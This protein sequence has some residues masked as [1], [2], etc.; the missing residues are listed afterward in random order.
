MQ[1]QII[2][3]ENG[4]N[5]VINEI[6]EKILLSE[7]SIVLIDTK[8]EDIDKIDYLNNQA[9][10]TLKNG[11]KIIV[12]NFNVEESSLVFRN[13]QSELFIYDFN[14]VSYNPLSNIELLLND[15][16]N[17]LIDLWPWAAGA[18]AIGALAGAGGGSSGK[19]QTNIAHEEAKNVA[20]AESA[21]VDAIDTTE[22]AKTNP[23]EETIA[24]A[25]DAIN[26]AEEAIAKVT[27]ADK[28]AELVADLKDAQDNLAEAIEAK[29]VADANSAIADAIDAAE[30]A[31]VD[32]TEA[33]IDA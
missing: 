23:T 19:S 33:N 3:K 8:I 16:G 2:S 17:F 4:S 14:S 27:D 1:V 20:D 7:N 10:I 26:V 29:N 31:K 18:V 6:V 15:S 5:S 11:E 25:E 32:P 9:V 30:E 13:E 12:D 22:A 24:A 21:I 28:Q